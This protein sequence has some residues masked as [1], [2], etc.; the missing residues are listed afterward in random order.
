MQE[1]SKQCSEDLANAV[2]YCISCAFQEG[3]LMVRNQHTPAGVHMLI[4]TPARLCQCM[5]YAETVWKPIDHLAHLRNSLRAQ[6]SM[7]SMQLFVP[8]WKDKEGEAL[9]KRLCFLTPLIKRD[10]V[11]LHLVHSAIHA[12]LVDSIS[13]LP[14]GSVQEWFQQCTGLQ[15]GAEAITHAEGQ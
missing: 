15:Q 12:N 8:S 9:R 13:S 5:K 10:E 3:C 6:V 1:M 4:W 14:L 2:V 7:D 11:P